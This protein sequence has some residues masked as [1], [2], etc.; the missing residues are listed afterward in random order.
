MKLT[1]CSVYDSAAQAFNR[2]LFVPHAN[3]AR[4]S[5]QDEINR[6]GDQNNQ[7]NTHPEDFI[8]YELGT[9][10]DETARFDLLP[11]PRIVARAKDLKD[12]L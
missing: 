1:I 11:E 7:M 4:R 2:P 5:F 12:S 8:L 9:F 6:G 10:D 3:L